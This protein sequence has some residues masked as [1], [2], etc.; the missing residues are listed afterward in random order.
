MHGGG[1]QFGIPAQSVRQELLQHVAPP[2]NADWAGISETPSPA[3]AKPPIRFRKARRLAGA[4][5]SPLPRSRSSIRPPFAYPGR[6]TR[7]PLTTRPIAVAERSAI[8]NNGEQ[9]LTDAL[10]VG[11]RELRV[12]RQRERPLVAAIGAGKRPL[13]AVGAEAVERIRADLGL[14]AFLPQRPKRLVAAVDLHHGRRPAV[15]VAFLGARELGDRGESFRIGGGEPLPGA[16]K[17]LEALELRNPDRAEDVR[18]AVVE[19][20]TRDLE[21]AAAVDAVVAHLADPLGEVCVRGRHGPALARRDDLARVERQAAEVPEPAARPPA[22]ASAE[23]SGRVLDERDTLR[24]SV[25]QPLPVERPAEE[26]DGD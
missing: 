1:P 4:A 6:P 20:G 25:P 13:V 11:L 15:P 23:R 16:E 12:E 8:R 22:A 14:D 21:V 24:Q 26:V 10:L 7:R 18:E 9:D 3:S 17:L 19:T 2:A 5:D